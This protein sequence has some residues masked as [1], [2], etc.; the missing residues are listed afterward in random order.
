MLILDETIDVGYV[1]RREGLGLSY[2]F[3]SR[4]EA[5]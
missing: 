5:P 2:S 3:P 4:A 1:C